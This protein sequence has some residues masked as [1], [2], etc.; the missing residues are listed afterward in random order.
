VDP[1]P[2]RRHGRSAS[3]SLA[4][5]QPA[6]EA[7][8]RHWARLI[9]RGRQAEAWAQVTLLR[10][11]A[12]APLHARLRFRALELHLRL[13]ANLKAARELLLPVQQLGRDAD[14]LAGLELP[15]GTDPAPGLRA[16]AECRLTES[17]GYRNTG[18]I[19]DALRC[20][21]RAEALHTELGDRAAALS[22]QAHRSRVYFMAGMYE[23]LVELGEALLR[24]DAALSPQDLLSV[25]TSTASGYY[26]Q[27]ECEDRPGYRERCIALNERALALAEAS[28]DFRALCL[29]HLNLGTNVAL[30]G[31]VPA[32]RAHLAAADELLRRRRTPGMHGLNEQFP[33]ARRYV[34]AICAFH[35]GRHD[36]A[37]ATLEEAAVLSSDMLLMRLRNNIV[38][39]QVKLAEQAGRLDVALAAARRLRGLDQE[40]AEEHIR[41][42]VSDFSILSRQARIDAEHEAL[43]SDGG[44]LERALAQ[45]NQE[46][47]AT[48]ARLQSEIELRRATESAL[49]CT[50]DELERKAQARAQSVHE[51]RRL[52]ARQEKLAALGNLGAGL[53]HELNTPIGNARLVASTLRDRAALLLQLIDAGGLRREQLLAL[54]QEAE[55]GVTLLQQSLQRLQQL[56]H[57]LQGETD[58]AQQP[59]VQPFDASAWAARV[60]Q[61]QQVL[62]EQMEATLSLQAPT[63][64][65][66]SG[67]ALAFAQVLATLLDNAL[68]HGLRDRTG[69]RVRLELCEQEQGLELVVA[70]DGC[71]LDAEHRDRVFEPFFTTRFGQGGSGLGLYLAH[72]LA[73]QRLGGDLSLQDNPGGGSR[74]VL[75]MPRRVV[76]GVS[77]DGG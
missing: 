37:F 70:D 15:A 77:S 74:F 12:D 22:M 76:A 38:A 67:D 52:L 11:G 8:L 26:Y 49:Q 64:C 29:S 33:V 56:A 14:E 24:Q 44:E 46:L 5:R 23:Q 42:L 41:H 69:G 25:L 75:R 66:C 28:G 59:S 65:P 31:K 4:E 18:L 58:E 10:P 45:R 40:L 21:A 72:Q 55:G 60:M 17:V 39:T 51:A 3:L 13:S 36:E 35:E 53:A 19:P 30:L 73:R 27:L 2:T 34:E 6:D 71:G 32:A 16:E 20:L 43:L 68:R 1:V 54:A 9:A 50:H 63:E 47:S 7:A 62:A 57:K 48:L 61:D